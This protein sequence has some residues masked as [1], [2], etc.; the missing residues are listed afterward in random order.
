MQKLRGR[1]AKAAQVVLYDDQT[2]VREMEDERSLL[3]LLKA[4]EHVNNLVLLVQAKFSP[5][6]CVDQRFRLAEGIL[7]VVGLRDD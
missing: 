3:C 6:Q 2:R 1:I 7:E 5:R 4:F